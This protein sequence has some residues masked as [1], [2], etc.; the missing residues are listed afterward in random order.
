MLELGD[1]SQQY[2]YNVV[3]QIKNLNIQHVISVG[4]ETKIIHDNLTNITEK[5]HFDTTKELAENIFK[6]IQ[7][8]DIIL[9]KASHG[10]HFE[11]VISILRQA[12]KQ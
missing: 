1:K 5:W 9:F 11:N 10:L 6:I 7:N 4:Q 2:H 12:S 8:G 3:K